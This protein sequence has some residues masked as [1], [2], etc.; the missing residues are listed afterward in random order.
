MIDRRLTAVIIHPLDP[1]DTKYTFR[2]LRDVTTITHT[3]NASRPTITTALTPI[4]DHVRESLQGPASSADA[5][6][7][8]METIILCLGLGL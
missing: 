4:S 5:E 1:K 3:A 6:Y 2:I 7:M 8:P